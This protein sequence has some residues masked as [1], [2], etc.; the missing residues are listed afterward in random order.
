[1]FFGARHLNLMDKIRSN[2]I[3]NEF[4]YVITKFQGLRYKSLE[5]GGLD[6]IGLRF[7]F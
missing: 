1:V 6:R 7:E 4:E 3:S 2:T 5:F